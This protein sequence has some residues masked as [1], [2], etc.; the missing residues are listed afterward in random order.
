MAHQTWH[1]FPPVSFFLNLRIIVWLYCYTVILLYAK[2][3]FRCAK[4]INNSNYSRSLFFVRC[5]SFY[6]NLGKHPIILVLFERIISC[7]M[8]IST[9]YDSF[10]QNRQSTKYKE[11]RT[12]VFKWLSTNNRH[13]NTCLFPLYFSY[14]SSFSSA[15]ILKMSFV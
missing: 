9:D 1:L 11:R 14:F 12:W 8:P 6:V 7:F 3:I 10:L 4:N 15:I 2:F 5:T 13:H